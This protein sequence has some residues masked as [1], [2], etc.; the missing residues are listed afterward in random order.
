MHRRRLVNRRLQCD[1]EGCGRL[2]PRAVLPSRTLVAHLT[3][4]GIGLFLLRVREVPAGSRAL[5][6]LTPTKSFFSATSLHGRAG[7]EPL[8]RAPRTAQPP[9]LLIERRRCQPTR[10]IIL[11]G[12]Q[13]EA[14]E[15]PWK[16]V[17]VNHWITPIGGSNGN[18]DKNYYICK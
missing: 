12:S 16:G 13:K 6:S 10:G 17:G 2:D 7:G 5:R 18:L 3:D 11:D 14:T 8:G 15:G 9:L 1:R 4:T